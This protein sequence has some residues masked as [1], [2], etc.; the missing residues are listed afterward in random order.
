MLDGYQVPCLAA[1]QKRATS[2]AFYLGKGVVV[3][4]AFII[5]AGH[6]EPGDGILVEQA[7][8]LN[9]YIA[10]DILDEFG[11]VIGTLGDT[12]LVGA[13]ENGVELAG[14]TLLCDID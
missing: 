14:G 8:Q 6:V 2:A 13:F 12:L 1:D 3:V 9:S 4:D 11:V 5:V 7:E 10:D